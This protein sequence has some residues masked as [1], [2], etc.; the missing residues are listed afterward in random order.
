MLAGRISGSDIPRKFRLAAPIL[1][2]LGV[3]CGSFKP[4]GIMIFA[5]LAIIAGCA[6][7]V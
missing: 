6:S 5:T 2:I 7:K 3:C 4:N 1:A